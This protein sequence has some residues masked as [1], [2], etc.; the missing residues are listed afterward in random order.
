M[1]KEKELQNTTELV[2]AIL[3]EDEMARNSDNVLY[4]K[5]V[6]K[7]KPEVLQEPFWYVLVSLKDYDLPGFETVRRTRQ[8]IQ[9]HHPELCSKEK[10]KMQKLLNEETFEEYARGIV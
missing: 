10:V 6:E 1:N 5:V 3:K 9:E 2:K 7:L 8:K 4:V